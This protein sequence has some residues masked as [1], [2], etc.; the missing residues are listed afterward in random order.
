MERQLDPEPPVVP[1]LAVTDPGYSTYY[2]PNIFASTIFCFFRFLFGHSGGGRWGRTSTSTSWIT[3]TSISTSIDISIRH[4]LFSLLSLETMI[5]RRTSAGSGFKRGLENRKR[6]Q[7]YHNHYFVDRLVFSRRLHNNLI[8]ILASFIAV[9]TF[10]RLFYFHASSVATGK[11]T[12][13]AHVNNVD[14]YDYNAI[15]N[16]SGTHKSY[17][18]RRLFVFDPFGNYTSSDVLN[19]GCRLTVVIVDPRPPASAYNHPIWYALES[20]AS[21]V[22]YACVVIQTAACQVVNENYNDATKLPTNQQQ[23][24]VVAKVIYEHALPLFRRMMESGR[25]RVNILNLEKYGL[26]NCAHFGQGN[27][28]FKSSHFWIDEFIEGLDSNMVLTVQDDSVLCRPFEIDLWKHFAFVGAPWGSWVD[29]DHFRRLW[30]QWA[31][32]CNGLTNYQLQ[33]SMSRYCTE[34]YGGK[35]GN[36]GLSVR[37]RSWMV[38]AIERCPGVDNPH[39]GNEDVYFSTILNAMNATMPSGFEASLFSVESLFPEQ[40]TEYLNLNQSQIEEAIT[41]LWG[42]EPTTGFRLYEKMHQLDSYFQNASAFESIPEL[43]TIPLGFH[44]PWG[45]LPKEILQ[46]AQVQK[47]CKFL[48]FIF[49]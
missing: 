7:V 13:V 26:H 29:C 39:S 27:S 44:K 10:T 47:E 21:Y 37:N 43:F 12:A 24:A 3:T 2:P 16:S 14:S 30:D 8:L 35:Q 46:G 31:P 36:G 38:E 32:R 15:F 18:D 4:H 22:P 48:K 28:I 25:V 40:T 20:V 17:M 41:R 45:F 5:Q 19:N 9:V 49:D 1:D 42:G 23:A 6:A 34:G 33:E 11:S